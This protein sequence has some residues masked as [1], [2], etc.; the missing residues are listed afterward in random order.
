MTLF[1]SR[2][3]IF[4]VIFFQSRSYIFPVIRK[5]LI[6]GEE[7]EK[8]AVKFSKSIE[9]RTQEEEEPPPEL[10]DFQR[11]FLI[12]I[13]L[14]NPRPPKYIKT[15]QCDMWYDNRVCDKMDDGSNRAEV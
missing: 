13:L 6:F 10:T 11:R 15:V 7:C 1:Q 3:D 2:F 5:M 12:F 4:S 14:K 8:A 9:C